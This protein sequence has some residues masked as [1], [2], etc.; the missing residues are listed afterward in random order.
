MIFNIKTIRLSLLSIF[1]VLFFMFNKKNLEPFFFQTGWATHRWICYYYLPTLLT[2]A[3]W[4]VYNGLNKSEKT[5][6]I[7]RTIAQC[8]YEIYLVQMLVFV[9]ISASMLSFISST[10]VRL[11]IWI[12]LTYILSI[13]G[14]IIMN[15]CL[16]WVGYYK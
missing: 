4:L 12:S 14:G 2:Y 13:V 7:I 10:V 3:L 6:S 5:S 11:T 16:K 8:S 15:R 1:A 9:S